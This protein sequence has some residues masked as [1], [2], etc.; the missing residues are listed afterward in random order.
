MQNMVSILTPVFVK[1]YEVALVFTSL[2]K[3]VLNLDN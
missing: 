1:I 3:S 2:K